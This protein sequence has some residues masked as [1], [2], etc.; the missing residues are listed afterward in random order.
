MAMYVEKKALV[1]LIVVLVVVLGASGYTIFSLQQTAQAAQDAAAAAQAATKQCQPCGGGLTRA[2][3][4]EAIAP[5]RTDLGSVLAESRGSRDEL[6]AI[7]AGLPDM[8]PIVHFLR[9]SDAYTELLLEDLARK[10]RV[11]LATARAA[12]E[13]MFEGE[14]G[15]PTGWFWGPINPEGR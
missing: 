11:D 14:G 4:E 6:I 2:V 7:R 9:F 1:I 3:L 5:L 8:K 13:K 10:A 12:V 15:K